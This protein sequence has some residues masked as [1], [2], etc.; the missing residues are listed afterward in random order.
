MRLKRH[1][2]LIVWQKAIDLAIEVYRVSDMIPR[3]EM[4]ALSDQM[5]KTAVSI[6]SKIAQGQDSNLAEE[7]LRCLNHAKGSKGKLETQLLICLRLKYVTVTDIVEAQTQ[8]CE[9][10]ELINSIGKELAVAS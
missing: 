3:E 1:V 7:Y 8:L 6:P 9:V 10:G 2:D 4:Y 5:K